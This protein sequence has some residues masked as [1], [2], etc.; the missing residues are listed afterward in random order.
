M[1]DMTGMGEVVQQIEAVL[2]DDE[3]PATQCELLAM[4][5]IL[6]EI[7]AQCTKARDTCPPLHNAA[8]PAKHRS[9]PGVVFDCL[10]DYERRRNTPGVFRQSAGVTCSTM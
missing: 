5:R 6:T 1:G 8:A 2:D 4:R 10:R 3:Y 7:T 9:F